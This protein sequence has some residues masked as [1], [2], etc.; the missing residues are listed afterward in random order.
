MHNIIERRNSN[1]YNKKVMTRGKD[2]D[3]KNVEEDNVLLK[4][5]ITHTL[6][7]L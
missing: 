3:T 4:S 1:T 5:P 6:N 2:I 7:K